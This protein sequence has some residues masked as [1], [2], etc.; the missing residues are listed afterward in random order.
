MTCSNCG[1]PLGPDSLVLSKPGDVKTVTPVA[2]VCEI[3]LEG[4][5]VAK[6][7]VAR[8]TPGGEFAYEQYLPVSSR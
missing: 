1:G 2:A 6:V 3:C 8:E 7:V 4:V 5:T